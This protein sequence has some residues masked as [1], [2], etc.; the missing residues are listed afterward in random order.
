MKNAKIIEN[1]I[2]YTESF[3]LKKSI[4]FNNNPHHFKKVFPDYLNI[5]L[6][7]VIQEEIEILK[8]KTKTSFHMTLNIFSK[9]VS[10]YLQNNFVS[11]ETINEIETLF[12]NI[13][14]NLER[15]T[16]ERYQA[17]EKLEI[18]NLFAIHFYER[19][20]VASFIREGLFLNYFHNKDNYI[21]FVDEPINH[22]SISELSEYLNKYS[23][24]FLHEPLFEE[25]ENEYHPKEYEDAFNLEF[26]SNHLQN[27]SKVFYYFN[28]YVKLMPFFCTTSDEETP[29]FNILRKRHEQFM[30]L[31]L[32]C[33]KNIEPEKLGTEEV[34]DEISLL[35]HNTLLK[36]NS[37]DLLKSRISKK[38][39]YSFFPK[40]LEFFDKHWNFEKID[41]PFEENIGFMK[42]FDDF[43]FE[44]MKKIMAFQ[45]KNIYD[46]REI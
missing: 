43:T 27:Q 19:I 12:Y 32:A 17:K 18:I 35:Y 2:T 11:K 1:C 42:V 31:F 46:M 41:E 24:F 9:K 26:I 25:T 13:T 10:D 4:Y 23:I 21:D 30:F 28:H 16:T 14:G 5:T 20:D 37:N 39:F 44:D 15:N 34:N 6:Y 45:C 3:L 8:K 36:I 40:E 7:S 38:M 29:K 22:F 33:L